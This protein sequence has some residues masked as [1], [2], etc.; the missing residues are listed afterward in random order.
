MN[1]SLFFTGISSPQAQGDNLQPDTSSVI[2]SMNKMDQLTEINELILSRSESMSSIHCIENFCQQKNYNIVQ[3]LLAFAHV[4]PLSEYIHILDYCFDNHA[5]WENDASFVQHVCLIAQYLCRGDMLY[6]QSTW[7]Q[8]INMR[9]MNCLNK[10]ISLLIKY[11]EIGSNT[12]YTQLKSVSKTIRKEFNTVVNNI[13]GLNN[14]VSLIIAEF[15]HQLFEIQQT[16][17]NASTTSSNF[18]NQLHYE[19]GAWIHLIS[20]IDTDLSQAFQPLI[21][22]I[23]RNRETYIASCVKLNPN[24]TL[25]NSHKLEKIC[26]KISGQQAPS[27]FDPQVKSLYQ[28]EAQIS[29][30][31]LKSQAK[32][33]KSIGA[34]IPIHFV[35][36]VLLCNTK[37]HVP[38]ELPTFKHSFHCLQGLDL[39]KGRNI[40]TYNDFVTS[41]DSSQKN[42]AAL[43]LLQKLYSYLESQS[44]TDSATPM[45]IDHDK[46][47]DSSEE[48]TPLCVS[49]NGELPADTPEEPTEPTMK[50]LFNVAGGPLFG[51]HAKYFQ[52]CGEWVAPIPYTLYGRHSQTKEQSRQAEPVESMS[53]SLPSLNQLFTGSSSSSSRELQKIEYQEYTLYSSRNLNKALPAI[54]VFAGRFR[55]ALIPNCSNAAE[56]FLIVSE[57]EFDELTRPDKDSLWGYHFLVIKQP[58]GINPETEK[59]A[60]DHTDS[61]QSGLLTVRRRVATLLG[62]DQGFDTVLMMDDNIKKLTLYGEAAQTQNPEEIWAQILRS[63]LKQAN[64]HKA[65]ITT[66]QTS[67]P[68]CPGDIQHKQRIGCKMLI[69]KMGEIKKFLPNREQSYFLYP[70]NLYASSEDAFFQLAVH[71]FANAGRTEH[72]PVIKGYIQL[73]QKYCSLTRHTFLNSP[74]SCVSSGMFAQTLQLAPHE[75]ASAQKYLGERYDDLLILYEIFNKTIEK[76]RDIRLKSNKHRSEF[77]IP[78][79]ILKQ[80]DLKLT[81]HTGLD[82]AQINLSAAPQQNFQKMLLWLAD[83]T[84]ISFR[85]PQ[86]DCLKQLSKY[87]PDTNVARTCRLPTGV[88]KTVIEACL[89]FSMQHS[90][91]NN[92]TIVIAPT[93]LLS[94][95]LDDDFYNV[96]QSFGQSFKNQLICVSSGNGLN[97]PLKNILQNNTIMSH[98]S[99]GKV[100]V[101]CCR[102]FSKLLEQALSKNDDAP[103]AQRFLGRCSQL[104]FDEEHL[105][106]SDDPSDNIDLSQKLSRTIS[107]KLLPSLKYIHGFS[108]TPRGH[109]DFKECFIKNTNIK[110]KNTLTQFPRKI[111]FDYTPKQAVVDGFIRPLESE[112]TQSNSVADFLLAQQYGENNS[113]LWNSV[114]II[115]CKDQQQ[116]NDVALNLR[117]SIQGLTVYCIHNANNNYRQDIESF[118]NTQSNSVALVLRML[119]EGFNHKPLLYVI[120]LKKELSAVD[121]EQY[122]GRCRRKISPNDNSTAMFFNLKTTQHSIASRIIERQVSHNTLVDSDAKSDDDD[123]VLPVGE[124]SGHIPQIIQDEPEDEPNNSD[125]IVVTNTGDGDQHRIINDGT[126]LILSDNSSS[127]SHYP[128]QFTDEAFQPCTNLIPT[129]RLNE[130]TD[131]NTGGTVL[132]FK[133]SKKRKPK[134]AIT[135]TTKRSF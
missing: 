14:H 107:D 12:D 15:I 100:F 42:D 65:I 95:Q 89:A 59:L 10:A 17:L 13:H 116:L 56:T 102:S 16:H 87:I 101:F 117:N 21:E 33:Y 53:Y 35:Y 103:I 112:N 132:A 104:I 97:V 126:P 110:S 76:N 109:K 2:V 81:P 47:P 57:K 34:P 45:V 5:Q 8:E 108:A 130:F 39:G 43:S 63:L 30:N 131:L 114:G 127:S 86:R 92:H 49:I 96:A 67:T 106:L 4:R 7:L 88:G 3:V 121:F 44:I 40:S 24:N 60:V 54:V 50:D 28:L 61:A 84:P 133:V 122:A 23:A 19:L 85:Q 118:K 74:K 48:Y 36:Y 71:F 77:N 9:N 70:T 18:F 26:R 111:V 83:S 72:S 46:K 123:A 27:I 58:W 66:V 64:E 52:D 68:F 79:A 90:Y 55:S 75:N 125:A 91:P 37:T 124:H 93:V 129:E 62:Y 99:S 119:R 94:S 115:V 31:Q 1:N 29:Y 98:D 128:G 78:E 120:S 22:A 51:V 113:P 82:V 69:V 38:L 25:S 105:T 6:S 80:R 135:T 20:E 73:S 41:L 32:L 11:Q 134:T